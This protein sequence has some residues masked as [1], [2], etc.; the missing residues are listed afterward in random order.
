[1]K[2]T[3]TE[4]KKMIAESLAKNLTKEQV[5]AAAPRAARP[6]MSSAAPT[7]AAP[8]SSSAPLDLDQVTGN[9]P[10]LDRA[11][12]NRPPA[13]GAAPARELDALTQ[14]TTAVI[15]DLTSRGRPGAPGTA[16]RSQLSLARRV[17]NQTP[18][19]ATNREAQARVEGYLNAA[20]ESIAR[21][22]QQASQKIQELDMLTSQSFAAARMSGR[23]ESQP[24]GLAGITNGVPGA[25]QTALMA[26]R[27]SPQQES[28][29]RGLKRILQMM[30][31]VYQNLQRTISPLRAANGGTVL[32]T[33]NNPR[34]GTQLLQNMENEITRMPEAA[35]IGLRAPASGGDNF[36]VTEGEA[37][38]DAGVGMMQRRPGS[39]RTPEMPRPAPRT[40]GTSSVVEMIRKEV[41]KVMQEQAATLSL[42]QLVAKAAMGTLTRQ[43]Q[44]QLA[45]LMRNRTSAR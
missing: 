27:L 14:R 37:P 41:K 4:L 7:S 19:Y 25:A 26:R 43:E 8:A 13:T 42:E 32:S 21:G 38:S 22:V 1:M 31:P 24:T 40:S 9:N 5:A 35:L 10:N 30:L 36:T 34:T 15:R 29:I 2:V 28:Q 20:K 18:D 44:A 39:V 16:T 12:A 45:Q 23:Y 3:V 33:I 6:S 11:I 17:I